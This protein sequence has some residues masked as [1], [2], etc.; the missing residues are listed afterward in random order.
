M[1]FKL[2]IYNID[3]AKEDEL[4]YNDSF[5]NPEEGI[6][7]SC[8]NVL[9]QV[10]VP[11]SALPSSDL[12]QID[13]K[14]NVS[15]II[16]NVPVLSSQNPISHDNENI[17]SSAL[18]SASSHSTLSHLSAP[19]NQP[20][21]SFDNT[22]PTPTEEYQANGIPHR[23]QTTSLPL[24]YMYD[25]AHQ[26]QSQQVFG[27]QSAHEYQPSQGFQHPPQISSIPPETT[28]RSFPHNTHTLPQY[29]QH[30]QYQFPM[31]ESLPNLHHPILYPQIPFP[32]YPYYGYPRPM[33]YSASF[34]PTPTI[35]YNPIFY[36][37]FPAPT[38]PS[39]SA[40]HQFPN[41]NQFPIYPNVIGPTHTSASMT[42]Y[43][44][45]SASNHSLQNL[46]TNL[47]ASR[48]STLGAT[49]NPMISSNPNL[50]GETLNPSS[51]KSN[52]SVIIEL[53]QELKVAKVRFRS[54]LILI[55]IVLNQ[56]VGRS[57]MG[58]NEIS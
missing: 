27:S 3:L 41:N 19:T 49:I 58:T 57:S 14:P 42:G 28:D 55:Y 45:L 2:K 47:A 18:P 54:F 32:P 10:S 9:D 20:T 8:D 25:K 15:P 5:E 30:P 36:G 44:A 34:A 52:D 1:L 4:E 38:F 17:S 7:L 46:A 13:A 22:L 21:T 48:T 24:Q 31:Q 11:Q 33:D 40:M 50:L 53:L 26:A 29:H 12:S 23:P 35:G 51:K 37:Q 56:T 6:N 43:N 16:M 39:A